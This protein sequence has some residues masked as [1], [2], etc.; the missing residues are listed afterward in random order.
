MNEYSWKAALKEW[1]DRAINIYMFRMQKNSARGT[2]GRLECAV[3]LRAIG[4]DLGGRL[5]ESLEI[6]VEDGVFHVQGVCFGVGKESSREPLTRSY[7]PD[8]IYRLDELGAAR[9][10]AIPGTPDAS[11]LAESLRTVGRVVDEKKGHL[12]RLFK[13]H[14][15]IAFE[16]EDENGGRQKQEHYS[17]SH[18]KGQQEGVSQR[19]TK[20][21]E[22]VWKDSRG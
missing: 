8:D 2:G 15:K 21:R 16:Y 5:I 13:D 7:R 3:A 22:D 20:T 12:I 10:T 19:G 11:S 4:Q 18:Y 17:L 9:Q 1:S 14:R 6:A